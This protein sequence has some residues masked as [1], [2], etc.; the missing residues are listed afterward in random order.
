MHNVLQWLL[1]RLSKKYEFFQ[2]IF[3]V[4]S[5]IL[6]IFSCCVCACCASVLFGEQETLFKN[7]EA[8]KPRFEQDT[9]I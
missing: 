4:I 1:G 3:G 8:E 5:R 6:Y 2:I 9:C 7:R